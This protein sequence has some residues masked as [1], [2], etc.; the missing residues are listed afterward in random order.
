MI[1][2]RDPGLNRVTTEHLRG[3]A[4]DGPEPLSRVLAAAAAPAAPYELTGEWPA[5][6]EYRAANLDPI[7]P[8]RR[9]S[10][11]KTPISKVLAAK[12]LAACA[13]AAVATGGIAVAAAT[14]TLPEQAQRAAHNA[15]NAP[16]PH[17]GKP[18][19]HPGRGNQPGAK[20]SDRNNGS[21]APSPSLQGL[22]HAYQAGVTNHHP[23]KLTSPAFHALVIAAGG[24]DKLTAYCTKLIGAPGTRP[25]DDPEDTS[26]EHPTGKPAHPTG[27]S[28]T[29]PN[30]KSSEH[31]NSGH[32]TSTPISPSSTHAS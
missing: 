17:H 32:P 31:P 1:T 23:K 12:L 21:P 7:G 5:L 14:N 27:K 24:A 4:A 15:F 8:P 22:C 25:S 20:P 11:L 16:A 6:A 3:G 13:V 28:S 30:G 10:M 18:K 19:D 2:H 9:I 29:H 26:S